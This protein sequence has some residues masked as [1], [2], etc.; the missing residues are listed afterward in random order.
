MLKLKFIIP[1]VLILL[2]GCSPKVQNAYSNDIINTVELQIVPLPPKVGKNHYVK[3]L[4]LFNGLY[5]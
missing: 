5:I 4:R 3:E 2:A 1:A